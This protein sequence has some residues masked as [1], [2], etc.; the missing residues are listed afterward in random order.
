MKTR[1]TDKIDLVLPHNE[2]PRPQ[3]ARDLW[4]NLNGRFQYAITDFTYK[5]PEEFDGDITVPFAVESELSGVG[6]RVS[7]NQILWYKKEFSVNPEFSG[8]RV[9][10]HFDAVD[11]Y[12]IVYLNGKKLGEHKGGYMPFSFDITDYICDINTLIL[13][14]YDPTDSGMQPRGKQSEKSHGFWY[15]S[16]TGIWKTVWLECVDDIYIKNIKILPDIDTQCV[17]IATELSSSAE[18]EAVVKEG[19]KTVF[20]GKISDNEKIKI[21][22]CRLWSP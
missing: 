4:Q 2:Y 5:I 12:S 21:G 17:S 3:M 13:R 8:K 22:N 15:T 20:E 14:V 7:A 11:W 16:T 18:I 1:W 19:E 9:L 10:L 6:K